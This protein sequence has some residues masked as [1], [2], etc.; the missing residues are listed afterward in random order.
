M[1]MHIDWIDKL[2]T[3]LLTLAFCLVIS[4]LYYAFQPQEPFSAPLA[5]SLCIGLLSWAFIDLGRHLL[6]TDPAKGWPEGWRGL[7]LPVVGIGLG[8]SLGT[9]LGDRWTGHSTWQAGSGQWRISLLVSLLAGVA[10]TYFFHSRGEQAW[11]QARIT[12]ARHQATEARLR[13]LEA[14]L[15]P[16][17]LFNTL[18][19]LRVL[20]ASDTP[21]ALLM[22]DRLNAYLRATLVASRSTAQPLHEAFAQLDDYLALMAVRMGPRLTYALTLPEALRHTQLPPLLLQPLVE[23]AIRHGLEPQVQGGHIHVQAEAQG[24]QLRIQVHDT[25]AGLG[26]SPAEGTQFGLPQ[27]RERLATLYGAQGHLALAAAPAG[28]TLATVTLPLQRHD[29]AP[30]PPGPDCRG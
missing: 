28:G 12:E 3:L 8:F 16:H 4:A 17:M 25:G 20:I 21:Q 30:T 27:V 11:L 18:A 26:L 29:P 7:L 14:Q 1:P 5:Y 10:I 24:P 23:N 15:E 22:L 6:A 19:N 9:L 13:L 2:R